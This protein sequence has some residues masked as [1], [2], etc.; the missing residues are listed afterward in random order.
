LCC[1]GAEEAGLELRL[2]VAEV[3]EPDGVVDDVLLPHP[4]TE[5]ASVVAATTP[6]TIV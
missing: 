3:P 1:A 6:A 4:A 5:T 2:L